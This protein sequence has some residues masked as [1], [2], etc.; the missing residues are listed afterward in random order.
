MTA[1]S[2][3]ERIV[4]VTGGANGIGRAVAEVAAR[5]GARVVVVDIDVSAGQYRCD[6]ADGEAVA[7]VFGRIVQA[8]GRIDVLVN[9]AGRNAYFD[10][11]EMTE[12]DWDEVF[13]VDLKA[14]WLCAKHALPSMLAQGRGSIVNVAS[15]HSRLTAAGMFPY[16]AAKSGLVGLTRS[17]ALEVA[18]RGVRV[19]AVSPGYTRTAIVQDYLDRSD[20]PSLERRILDVHPLGRIAE[21]AEIAEVVCFLASDAASFVTGAEWRVDGGLGARFA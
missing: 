16:A 8:Y 1:V 17:L 6:V 13:A 4:V 11:V 21:P 7:E 20:D 3:S 15:L 14:A 12:A 10:P 9:N 5:D 19:N 18:G 2:L